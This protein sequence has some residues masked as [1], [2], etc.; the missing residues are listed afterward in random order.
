[1]NVFVCLLK[2]LVRLSFIS[3]VFVFST[4]HSSFSPVLP[5]LLP[6]GKYHL[7]SWHKYTRESKRVNL[8]ILSPSRLS[9]LH[10]TMFA[11][12]RA[13]STSLSSST[14]SVEIIH[15]LFSLTSFYKIHLKNPPSQ[16]FLPPSN[17]WLASLNSLLLRFLSLPHLTRGPLHVLHYIQSH[18][19]VHNI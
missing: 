2:S 5:M 11:K 3:V 17:R 6:A 10:G 14:H 15:A 16:W 18:V 13:C 7:N 19:Q 1:M 12:R 9:S 8:L 4:S